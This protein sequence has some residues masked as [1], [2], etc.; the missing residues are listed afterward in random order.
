MREGLASALSLLK[1]DAVFVS[2]GRWEF[3]RR[4]KLYEPVVADGTWQQ[5]RN[6]L[7]YRQEGDPLP[8]IEVISDGGIIGYDSDN[9]FIFWAEEDD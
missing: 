1:P 3:T 2:K 7:W 5:R 6:H 8:P 9:A 4:G